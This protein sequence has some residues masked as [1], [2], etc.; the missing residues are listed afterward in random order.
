MGNSKRRRD[1]PSIRCLHSSLCNF[2]SLCLYPMLTVKFL[3]QPSLRIFDPL[4]SCLPAQPFKN[5]ASEIIP[6]QPLFSGRPLLK[7]APPHPRKLAPSS[8]H[9]MKDS[10]GSLWR[11]GLPAPSRSITARS[12]AAWT[13]CGPT[14]TG[15]S[16]AS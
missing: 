9:S 11:G 10:L 6:V 7:S 2:S 5:K 15:P 13:K 1:P 16:D 14:P 3:P 12:G 4:S 8:S